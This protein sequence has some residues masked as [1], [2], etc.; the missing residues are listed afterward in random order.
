MSQDYHDGFAVPIHRSL[1]EQILMGGCPRTVAFLNATLAAAM[2]IGLH[3]FYLLIFNVVIHL[4]MVEMT[5][6]DPQFF[7]CFRRHINLK[8]YYGIH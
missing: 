5:K 6:R 7:D 4:L 8:K 2:G 1:T 3:K